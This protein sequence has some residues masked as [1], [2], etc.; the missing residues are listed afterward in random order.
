MVFVA[1]AVFVWGPV[2]G[3]VLGYLVGNLSVNLHFLLLRWIGGRPLAASASGRRWRWVQRQLEG[4]ERHPVR[5]VVL[6]RLVAFMAPALNTLLALTSLRARD[7]LT[8]TAI[9]L[10][11][12]IAAACGLFQWI[13]A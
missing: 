9:G 1:A 13:F 10:L 2:P 3:F 8:G 5:V 11:L 6:L 4:L 12:P 7:H